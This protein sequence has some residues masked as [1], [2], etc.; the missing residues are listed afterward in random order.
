MKGG[1]ELARITENDL[2]SAENVLIEKT[3]QETEKSLK[4]KIANDFVVLD[5]VFDTDILESFSSREVGDI[6]DNF[7]FTV[8]GTSKT[9][10]F[11]TDDVKDLIE[12]FIL[13]KIP[14]GDAVYSNDLNI[15]YQLDNVDWEGKELTINFDITFET[16]PAIDLDFLKEELKGKSSAETRFLLENQPEIIKTEI[17]FWP[18]WV[19]TIPSDKN[20][21]EV[22]YPIID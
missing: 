11:K 17:S 1:G 10:S 3:K 20:R 9:I 7:S 22:N 19:K 12:A 21:I 16:Y 14:G 6:L 8:R 4:D 13:S 5:D 2:E 18:F 15:N